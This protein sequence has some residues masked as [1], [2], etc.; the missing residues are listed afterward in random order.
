MKVAFAIISLIAAISCSG[1]GPVITNGT[2]DGR[3]HTCGYV[4][5]D[6][7]TEYLDAYMARCDDPT[8]AGD[9]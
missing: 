5:A 9:Y 4:T 8:Y 2:T 7:V 6:G 1:D 3:F